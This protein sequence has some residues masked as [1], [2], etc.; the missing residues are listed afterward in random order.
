MTFWAVQMNKTAFNVA[1]AGIISA[2]AAAGQEGAKGGILYG[3]L[4]ANG[5]SLNDFQLITNG[6]E[7]TGIVA[8]AGQLYTLTAKGRALNAQIDAAIAANRQRAAA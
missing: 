8:K 4:M 5:Y 6:L 3:A 7:R 1:A 2:I